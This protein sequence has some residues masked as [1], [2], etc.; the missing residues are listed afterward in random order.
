[1]DVELCSFYNLFTD[2]A[3]FAKKVLHLPMGNARFAD[4]QQCRAGGLVVC[5]AQYSVHQGVVE[6]L[7][8]VDTTMSMFSFQVLARTNTHNIMQTVGEFDIT[9][10]KFNEYL[11]SKEHT[12]MYNG[13]QSIPPFFQFMM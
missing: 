3:K 2:G 11:Y 12:H 1:M 7:K 8:C 9:Q 10:E 6:I 13:V 4:W 5:F